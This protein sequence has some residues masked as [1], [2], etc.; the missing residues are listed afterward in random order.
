MA[1]YKNRLINI[2]GKPDDL[3]GRK[4]GRYEVCSGCR[5]R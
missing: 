4:D 3:G 5:Y 2:S 1:D